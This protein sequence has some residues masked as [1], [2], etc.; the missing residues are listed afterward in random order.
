VLGEGTLDGK[1]TVEVACAPYSA[2][3]AWAQFDAPPPQL[4]FSIHTSGHRPRIQHFPLPWI[5]CS[6]AETCH[7]DASSWRAQ[8]PRYLLASSSKLVSRSASRDFI[9]SYKLTDLFR[10]DRDKKKRENLANQILGKGRR[11]SAPAGGNIGNRKATSSAPPSLASRIG[12]NKVRLTILRHERGV[13]SSSKLML[14]SVQRPPPGR[15]AQATRN[16]ARLAIPRT[17]SASV[18]ER[19]NRIYSKIRSEQ[20][21]GSSGQFSFQDHTSDPSP[22]ISIRGAAGPCT[23]VASNFAPGTTALDISRVME[24]VGGEIISCRLVSSNPTVICE[25]VFKDRSGAENVVKMFNNR[26]VW[27]LTSLT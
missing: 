1:D 5:I 12:V 7:L 17:S 25:M 4:G 13:E 16:A 27:R 9:A 14:T 10:P 3:S 18:V 24:P 20:Q 2:W 22:G 11:D 15:N 26:K 6:Q 21:N 19:G 8:L 23:V